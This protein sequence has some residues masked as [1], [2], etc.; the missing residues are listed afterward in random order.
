VFSVKIAGSPIC[1][2]TS[3]R[4]VFF[5]PDG[6]L[7]SDEIFPTVPETLDWRDVE[8]EKALRILVQE[9]FPIPPHP[10]KLGAAARPD[11]F[12]FFLGPG[13]ALALQ[14]GAGEKGLSIAPSEN[15][16]FLPASRI[17]AGPHL[18]SL[19]AKNQSN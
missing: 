13:N 10:V 4:T 6:P 15:T 3:T 18:K 5:L 11:F 12:F 19:L 8:K 17:I 1:P 9:N 7:C 16:F 14:R 2:E